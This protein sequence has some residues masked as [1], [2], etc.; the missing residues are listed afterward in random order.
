MLRDGEVMLD[1]ATGCRPDDLFWIFSASKPYVAMLVHLLAEHGDLSLD[2]PVAR[3][4][5]EFGRYGKEAITIRHVLRHRAGVPTCWYPDTTAPATSATWPTPYSRRP[6]AGP[7][8]NFG[9]ISY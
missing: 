4:W 9:C 2:D 3:H 6:D 7:E 1:R 8:P 5:P